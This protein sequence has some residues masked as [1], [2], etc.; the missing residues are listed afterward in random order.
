MNNIS[1]IK[2]Y[3]STE[4]DNCSYISVDK[5]K[6]K[7]IRDLVIQAAETFKTK[8]YLRYQIENEIQSVSFE[9]LLFACE[10]YGAWIHK[11]MENNV[12]DS[13]RGVHVGLLGIGN[14]NYYIAYLG[15]MFSGNITIPMDPNLD[16]NTLMYCI[17]HGDVD[18]IFYEIKFQSKIDVL[19]E[20]CPNVKE[21]ILLEKGNS[22]EIS[23]MTDLLIKYKGQKISKNIKADDNTLM[24]Y[25]SGTTGKKKGVVLTHDNLIDKFFSTFNFKGNQ[26]EIYLCIL[27]LYHIFSSNDFLFS[28]RFGF[29]VC[30]DF[31]ISKLVKNLQLYQPTKTSLVPLLA[32]NLLN[33]INLNI[34]EHPYIP[35]EEAKNQI[36]G[37]NFYK[38]QSGGGYLSPELS[39]GF[40]KYGIVIGQGYGLTETASKASLSDFNPKK[41]ASVGRVAP[42]SEIRIYN[43]EIQIKSRA[44]MKEYYKDPERTK[45]AFTE[46][47]WLHTGDIGYFDEDGYLYLVGREKNLIILSNGENVSPEALETLYANEALIQ[48]ILVYGYEDVLCAEVYPN[49]KYAEMNNISEEEI[50]KKVWNIIEVKNKDLPSYERI[51]KLSIRNEPFAKTASKKIIRSEFMKELEIREKNKEKIKPKEIKKPTNEIQSKL[52]QIIFHALGKKE[53]GIDS[54][55]YEFGLDSFSCT[56]IMNEIRKEFNIPISLNFVVHNSSVEKLEKYISEYKKDENEETIDFS[57]RDVY[58]TVL[59]QIYSFGVYKGFTQ[60]NIPCLFRLHEDVD[61]Q[62]LK[63]SIEKLIDINYELKATIHLDEEGKYK[64]YRHDERKADI[65]ISKLTDKEWEEVRKGLIYPYNFTEDELLY[66]I[67]IYE[68]ETYNYLYFDISHLMC[69]GISYRNLIDELNDIYEGKI[70][71]PKKYSFF[72]YSLENTHNFLEVFKKE[73]GTYHNKLLEGLT[74]HDNPFMRKDAYNSK[75]YVDAQFIDTYS[76]I[77]VDK[78][79]A[80]CDSK[81]IT[82]NALF[83]FAAAHALNLYENINDCALISLHNG[84]ISERWNRVCGYVAKYYQFRFTEVENE[85]VVDAIHRSGKQIMETMCT[86]LPFITKNNF[87]FQYQGRIRDFNEIGGKPAVQEDVLIDSTFNQL[88]VFLRQNKFRYVMNYWSNVYDTQQLDNYIHIIED[89]VVGIINGTEYIKD[90]RSQISEKYFTNKRSCSVE[91]L[92]EAIGKKVFVCEDEKNTFINTYILNSQLEKQFIG[93]WGDIYVEEN[94]YINVKDIIDNPFGEGKLFKI[95]YTGKFLPDENQTINVLEND[96]RF[97]MWALLGF[98]RYQNINIIEKT[99]EEYEGIERA[100]TDLKF[101][102]GEFAIISN[103]YGENEPDIEKVKEYLKSKLEERIVPSEIIYHKME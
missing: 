79:H 41:I 82:D 77:D 3:D 4:G 22:T 34:Q 23:N 43:G 15:T 39:E 21:Y 9:E 64:N 80:F 54:D 47:G 90:L 99:L 51:V 6:V 40:R 20:K 100:S 55:L 76:K 25:T 29:T 36:V 93:G 71:E 96:C 66:H 94:E 10:T 60:G 91:E 98:E 37:K 85:K 19:K 26:T 18:V 17:N 61:L 46:D 14:Y 73:R 32:K 45:E 69:D 97:I 101:T 57:K 48:E 72:E 70:I 44:V 68:T 31:D 56:I 58:P 13:E 1:I 78:F 16:I 102:N 2:N 49:F 81:S 86:T 75:P 83:M 67:G 62:K 50:K 24:I 38:I 84:R 11:E 27:P 89:I 92:N 65:K 30:F 87:F 7:T 52:S 74:L 12:T 103:I 8:T 33:I 42:N 88:S 95:G 35:I 53:F 28:L 5:S 63:E 59:S